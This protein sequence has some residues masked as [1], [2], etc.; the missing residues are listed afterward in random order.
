MTNSTQTKDIRHKDKQPL[1]KRPALLACY[2]ALAMIVPNVL[3]SITEEMPLL[4]RIVNILVPL[5]VYTLLISKVKRIGVLVLWSFIFI[6]MNAMQLV[7]LYLYG[8]SIIAIDMLLNCL[9]T[10]TSEAGELL[11]NLLFPIIA[12]CVIYVP[13][14]IWAG[15]MAVRK[16][17]TSEK[18]RNKTQ[19]LG[20]LGLS[21]GIVLTIIA[22]L[23]SA[24]YNAGR[25]IYPFNVVSNICSALSRTWQSANYHKTSA[26][27]TFEA[28]DTHPAD[29]EEIHILVIGE[30]SRADNWQLLGYKRETTPLLSSRSDLHT[31]RRAVSQ[32]NTTH[33]CVPM[34]LTQTTPWTFDSIM[35]RK[36][37]ITAFNEA[38][39]A[40]S[41]LSN[42]AKNHSYTQYFGEE[43]QDVRYLESADHYDRNLLPLLSDA[44][45]NNPGKKKFIIL[46]TYGSHFNYKDRYPREF[47][48]FTPDNAST[49]NKIHRDQLLNAYDN[50]IRYTDHFLNDIIQMVDSLGI[51][52][53]ITFTSDHGEDIFDDYRG[54]FLHASPTATYTQLHVPMFIWLSPQYREAYPEVGNTIADNEQKLV[55]PSQAIFDTLIDLSGLETPVH[56]HIQSVAHPQYQSPEPVYLSDYNDAEPLRYSGIKQIDIDNFQKLGIVLPE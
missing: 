53:T 49:A 14:V 22:T 48:Y 54:R 42:Q 17:K 37:I 30:T 6:L 41:F 2:F 4:G 47:A 40:T 8:E 15:Y 28:T 23:T 43:A 26:D 24:R 18:L 25:Q 34:M 10:N 56:N 3:L 13:M 19:R 12:A 51:K 46:H 1:F 38:G 50:T 5:S 27:Y 21:L 11:S 32:S 33:K 29:D 20:L 39:Y 31:F 36:S 55:A 16:F 44:L 35:Y 45:K 52:S 9:T 7:I